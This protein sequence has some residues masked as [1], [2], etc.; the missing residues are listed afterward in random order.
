MRVSGEA[1]I[2]QRRTCG[3]AFEA[4]VFMSIIRVP[5]VETTIAAAFDIF[6][7]YV[8]ILYLLNFAKIAAASG[9]PSVIGEAR[10]EH[11]I[12]IKGY[13]IWMSVRFEYPSVWIRTRSLAIFFFMSKSYLTVFFAFMWYSNVEHIVSVIAATSLSTMDPLV[14]RF[15]VYKVRASIGT[16][17]EC[18][19]LFLLLA[20]EFACV[21]TRVVALIRAL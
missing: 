20:F 15:A 17:R 1:I 10:C 19:F 9:A 21:N 8:A 14:R 13:T 7:R 12:G 5:V 6:H 11:S 3:E 16:F 4:H 2:D 18:L